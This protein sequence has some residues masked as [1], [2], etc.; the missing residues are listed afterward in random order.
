MP[1]DLKSMHHRVDAN[2]FEEYL[3]AGI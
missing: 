3:S 1:P 2:L